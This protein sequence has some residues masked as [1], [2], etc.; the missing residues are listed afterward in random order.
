VLEQEP[1]INRAVIAKIK[2]FVFIFIIDSLLFYL[3]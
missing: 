1:S 2:L 3:S